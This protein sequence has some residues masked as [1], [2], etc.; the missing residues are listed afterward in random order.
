MARRGGGH[1]GLALVEGVAV[2]VGAGALALEGRL[3]A[4]VT[5]APL[6]LIVLGADP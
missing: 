1:S 3:I 6:I 2:A 5:V 4:N